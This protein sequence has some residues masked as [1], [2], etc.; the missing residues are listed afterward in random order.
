M[1][2]IG[3]VKGRASRTLQVFAMTCLLF[4]SGCGIY[5]HDSDLEK[6]TKATKENFA[7][8][9]F[10]APFKEEQV[11]LK[12]FA[13]REDL[14]VANL[15]A[16]NRDQ[17]LVSLIQPSPLDTVTGGAHAHFTE[18]MEEDCKIVYGSC[19]DDNVT[20]QDLT[21]A[22]AL[23]SQRREAMRVARERYA[24]AVQE[25][26]TLK[27][28]EDERK[29]DCKALAAPSGGTTEADIAYQRIGDACKEIAKRTSDPSKL[30]PPN[31]NDPPIDFA[32]AAGS[33]IG[34]TLSQLAE[35]ES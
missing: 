8:L 23:I 25:F 12:D 31:P 15:A 10:S 16:A 32:P 7:K 34:V 28:K 18:L 9:D 35:H 30:T 4:P 29:T 19:P 14:A 24:D 22:P 13:D 6:T 26:S 3:P 11:R 20:L 21:V 27:S 33:A 2:L 5:L 1:L 17:V